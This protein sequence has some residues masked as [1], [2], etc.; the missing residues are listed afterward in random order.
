MD[1]PVLLFE[2]NNRVGLITLN[3]PERRNALSRQMLESL[4]AC[5]QQLARDSAAKVVIIK[6]TGTVFS[7]GHDLREL[8]H[9]TP[10]QAESLFSLCSEV[11]EL[12]RQLPQPV[13]AEIQG[14]ATAAGC[15]LAASC[16]MIVASEQ[17]SFATPGVK[18]GLFCTTPAVPL[19]RAIPTKKALEML[20][21]GVPISAQEAEHLGLV[22]RVVPLEKLS[23]TTLELAAQI[24]TASAATLALGKRAFYRQLNMDR[25]EAYQ[26]ASQ[27]MVENSQ[28]PD[29]KEGIDAFLKKRPPTWQS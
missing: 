21:T 26:L 10:E 19:C 4:R 24:A 25:P 13:I 6:S 2:I 7:S 28:M 15:Q 9:A 20:F 27:V 1:K 5:F 11:M 14:L 3:H 17:A 18:I 29:A 23:E 12:I 16:D 8:D 22:N